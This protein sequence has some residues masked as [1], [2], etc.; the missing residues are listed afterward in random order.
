MVISCWLK[1]QTNMEQ[2][3]KLVIFY[4]SGALPGPW[5]M[6][7]LRTIHYIL[8]RLIELAP[9][10]FHQFL[11]LWVVDEES[12][13]AIFYFFVGCCR[14]GVMRRSLS[15]SVRERAWDTWFLLRGPN[16]RL[17]IHIHIRPQQKK[18]LV[19]FIFDSIA[20]MCV[21]LDH[22]SSCVFEVGLWSLGT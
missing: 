10:L 2:Y 13:R 1:K 16:A 4:G 11:H 7:N 5:M 18:Q 19:D 6:I 17:C 15:S 21:S 14:F 20:I 3:N 9:M 22:V 8:D 12:V